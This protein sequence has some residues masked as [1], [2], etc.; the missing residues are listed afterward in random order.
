MSA[1]TSPPNKKA[2]TLTPH[3]IFDEELFTF[4]KAEGLAGSMLIRGIPAKDEVDDEDSEDDDDEDIIPEYT[5]EQ[6]EHIRHI[7]VTEER[8]A[9]VDLYVKK[10]L[11]DQAGSRFMMFNTSFSYH[12]FREHDYL[13]NDLKRKSLA[14]KF[15][16]LFAFS[17]I[18][19]KY[20]VWLHDHEDEEV[21]IAMIKDLAKRWKALLKK[22]DAELGI[23]TKYTRPGILVFLDTFKK[24]MEDAD[25]YGDEKI[26]FNFQ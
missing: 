26:A 7:L 14:K 4:I 9:M 15:N 11:G 5:P 18:I 19:M 3:E 2:K 17:Y 13:C 8:G 22:T 20:D 12:V 21:L 25:S 16:L 23:D 10:I 6:L 24:R 1:T